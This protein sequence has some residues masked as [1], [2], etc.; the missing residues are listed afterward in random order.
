MT[1]L[2]AAFECTGTADRTLTATGANSAVI[3]ALSSTEKSVDLRKVT[4]K[5]FASM[6]KEPSPPKW[7]GWQ[8]M[9]QKAR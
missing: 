7:R 5:Y 3:G 1:L 4:V 2:L 6:M 9:N 8:F